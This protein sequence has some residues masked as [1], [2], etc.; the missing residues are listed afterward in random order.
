VAVLF[1]LHLLT[2]GDG[3][4]LI[5]KL[6]ADLLNRGAV[7]GDDV[8]VK[9]SVLIWTGVTIEDGV[10]LGPS[11]VFTN[12]LRPRTTARRARDELDTTIVRHHATIG[13]NATIVCGLEI[14]AY[15]FVAAGAVVVRDVVPHELVAGNPAARTG[16]VCECGARLDE[17]LHCACGLR[18]RALPDDA[19]LHR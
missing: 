2:R 13:A 10:F 11:C 3:E 5:E 12:D 14:G 15:A 18:Y 1:R 7:V 6:A 16:W 9:N 4:D 17:D 19:G 8:T